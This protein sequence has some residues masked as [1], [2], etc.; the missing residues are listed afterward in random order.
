MRGT[1]P[2]LRR[3]AVVALAAVAGLAM[4][5][6]TA[7]AGREFPG[8]SIQDGK[9]RWAGERT[10]A[11]PNKSDLTV[12]VHT[13][14]YRTDYGEVWGRVKI[15]WHGAG[16]G[17]GHKFDGFR[18]VPRLERRYGSSG[19]DQIIKVDDCDV[20]QS[21]NNV[22]Q[23]ALS[24]YSPVADWNSSFYWSGDGYLQWDIDNDGKGWQSAWQLKGSPLMT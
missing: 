17:S 16:L 7:H 12:S 6:G 3:L 1:R 15:S 24:C 21:L 19:T 10:I 2:I 18:I 23:G 9:V 14:V 11:L 5:A 20:T 4:T 22:W 8:G 13:S